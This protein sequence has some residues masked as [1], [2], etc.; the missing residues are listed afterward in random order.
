MLLS[1]V[2][3]FRNEADILEELLRRVRAAVEQV[4]SD[5][6]LIFVND[7]STDASLEILIKQREADKRIKVLNMS[8]RFGVHPCVMAGMKYSRGDAVIYMDTDLQDP[9]E[10]IPQMVEKWRQGAAVVNMMRIKRLGE[11]PL[12]MWITKLAY[13][14]IDLMSDIDLPENVGDF[15]LLSRRVVDELVKL[16]EYDPY[17]R[18]LVRWV[19]FRQEEIQY[20]RQARFRGETHFSIFS[21]GPVKEFIRGITGFSA[22]PLYIAMLFGVFISMLS[23]LL[24]IYVLYCKFMETSVPGWA[25]PMVAILFLGGII[26]ITNGLLGLYI[27]RIYNQVKNRP[28][29]IIES[30]HGF[31][32]EEK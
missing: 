2:F 4:T 32:E 1:V 18:G 31:E 25:G 22:A 26:L 10:L 3:S 14:V 7:D 28:H 23:F 6:E 13:R 21:A 20:V 12:K 19:G 24:I 17:M 27:G 8:R 16:N 11:S 15:K 9:P 5:Y 29:F 30:T